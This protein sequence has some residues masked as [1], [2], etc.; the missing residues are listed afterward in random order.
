MENQ[1]FSYLDMDDAI[2][3]LWITPNRADAFI[4]E[5]IVAYEVGAITYRKTNI[6]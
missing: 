5:R 1:S 3:E 2:I 4:N 6:Q